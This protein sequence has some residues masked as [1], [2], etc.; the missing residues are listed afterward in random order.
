MTRDEFAEIVRKVRESIVQYIYDEIKQATVVVPIERLKCLPPGYKGYLQRG[1]G[2]APCAKISLEE[3]NLN[4]VFW[5]EL[6]LHEDDNRSSDYAG[7][8]AICV[9]LGQAQE[10]QE[11]CD[12][13]IRVYRNGH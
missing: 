3:K 6:L 9:L 5:L 13:I 1:Q 7:F 2:S 11:T 4:T 10:V 8:L 12:E